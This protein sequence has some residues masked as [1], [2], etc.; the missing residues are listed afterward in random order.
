MEWSAG[1]Q[2]PVLLCNHVHTGTGNYSVVHSLIHSSMVLQPFVG[3]WPLLHFRN[4]FY[5]DGRTRWTSDQPI[6]RPRPAHRATPTQN[7]RRQTSMRWVGFET[8][9]PAF[10]LAKTVHAFDRAATVIGLLSGYQGLYPQCGKWQEWKGDYSDLYR[11]SRGTEAL[12]PP[13]PISHC[14][15]LSSPTLGTT[16]RKLCFHFFF[17]LIFRRMAWHNQYF[18]QFLLHLLY[19]V[20]RNVQSF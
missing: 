14:C 13:P 15:V 8:T 12:P 19:I 3:P 10:E 20:F 4:L 18:D 5:T 11:N 2:F 6:A 16:W 7:K 1:V 9:I 17:H